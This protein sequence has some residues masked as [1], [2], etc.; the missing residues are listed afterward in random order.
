MNASSW[1][2]WLWRVA[3]SA[4]AL[5]ALSLH[6]GHALPAASAAGKAETS[7]PREAQIRIEAHRFAPSALT[8]APGTKV[9]WVNRDEDV[10]T[11]TSTTGAF[12]S[13]GLEAAEAFSF[14]PTK[15]GTYDYFCALHPDMKARLV[16]K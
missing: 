15:A 1:S 12:T 2:R 9:T 13:P 6:A 3:A 7:G 5:A 11:A 8:V 10:H 4:A 14:T 16:V